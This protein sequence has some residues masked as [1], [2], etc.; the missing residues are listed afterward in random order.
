[1]FALVAFAALLA[2]CAQVAPPKYFPDDP[3]AP[4]PV[5]P[6]TVAPKAIGGTVPPPPPPADRYVLRH[7]PGGA[8]VSRKLEVEKVH[9]PRPVPLVGAASLWTLTYRFDLTDANGKARTI[10]VDRTALVLSP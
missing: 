1:M 5:L 6:A 3:A 7:C 8:V 10:Y 2:P 4:T 9:P